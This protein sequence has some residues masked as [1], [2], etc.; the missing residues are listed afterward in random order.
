MRVIEAIFTFAVLANVFIACP[1]EEFCQACTG[2]PPPS[3][4]RVCGWCYHSVFNETTQKCDK[5]IPTKIDGC[6]KYRHNADEFV[7]D[8]CELGYSLTYNTCVKCK[9]ENCAYCLHGE[10]CFTC[11]NGLTPKLVDGKFV[12]SADEKCDVD[13]CN[14]CNFFTDR[15]KNCVL[16]NQGFAIHLDTKKCIPAPDNCYFTVPSVKGCLQCRDGFYITNDK[17]CKPNPAEAPSASPVLPH[18]R[19]KTIRRSNTKATS[20][21]L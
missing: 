8:V 6:A 19:V 1:D 9:V 7:C 2:P 12:C 17:K 15:E 13:N 20:M 18:P 11:F 10:G 14:V 21:P 16:C 3:D 4:V 5:N